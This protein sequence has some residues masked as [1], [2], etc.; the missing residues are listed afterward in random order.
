M[1]KKT[2]IRKPRT[3]ILI[4]I[5]AIATVICGIT[6]IW[7]THAYVLGLKS[8]DNSNENITWVEQSIGIKTPLISFIF[9][10]WDD[11]AYN[12]VA[13]IPYTLWKQRIYHIT[14][15]PWHMT[16]KEVASG[17]ADDMYKSFFQMIKSQHLKVI[18]R[19]MHEMNGWRYPR[20]SDPEN[21]KRAWKH[22]WEL[23]RKVGLTKEDILFDMSI[24]GRDMPTK[25]AAPHQQSTLMYCYPTQKIKLNCPTFEDYY[26]WDDYVDILW[27]TFYNRGKWNANRLRQTPYEIINHPQRRTLDRLKLFNKPLFVDEVGTTSIWYS[28]QYSQQKSQEEFTQDTATQRKDQRL[29]SLSIFLKNE[30][31]VIGWIYFNVDLTYGLAHWQIGEADWSIFDPYTKKIYAWGKRLFANATGNVRNDNAVYNAFGIRKTMR[32]KKQIF[33]SKLYGAKASKL[34]KKLLITNTTTYKDASKILGDYEGKILG[35]GSMLNTT[36]QK[37]IRYIINEAKNIIEQ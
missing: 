4:V 16:A 28:E 2:S 22:L 34:L 12:Q 27:F 24:N 8:R 10:S 21:F 11:Q 20:A 33:I 35:T 14:L 9:H 1:E 18:F 6:N 5:S 36:Q 3:K 7:W 17:N 30:P 25:D 13:Q 32:W 31:R 29:D 19:T 23:S 15:A 26:P 37:S